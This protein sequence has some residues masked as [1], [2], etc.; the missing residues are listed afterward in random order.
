MDGEEEERWRIR[1]G[2]DEDEQEQVMRRGSREEVLRRR[3]HLS[4]GLQC[5]GGL[6]GP[7]HHLAGEG[8]VRCR[9]WPR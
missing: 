7:E 5:E 2:G 4:V 3:H 1:T 8:G 6:M 9:P